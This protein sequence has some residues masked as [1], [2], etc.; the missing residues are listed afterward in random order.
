MGKRHARSRES[1]FDEVS[2]S[3][4]GVLPAER[5]P[6]AGGR[7]HFI[8]STQAREG[9]SGGHL[10]DWIGFRRMALVGDRYPASGRTGLSI[11]RFQRILRRENCSVEGVSRSDD[12]DTAMIKYV[13]LEDGGHCSAILTDPIDGDEYTRCCLDASIGV[14]LGPERLNHLNMW[15][16]F[17]KFYTPG[18]GTLLIEYSFIVLDAP[19]ALIAMTLDMFHG[20]VRFIMQNG[21][22][23]PSA[24][25][26]APQGDVEGSYTAAGSATAHADISPSDLSGIERK[27]DRIASTLDGYPGNDLRAVV[28]R[29]EDI[30]SLLRD[31]SGKL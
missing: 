2:E 16:K 8:V 4:G 3:F 28:N 5:A 24:T 26:H 30:R 25:A 15:S 21:F 17:P 31:I 11:D 22:R 14:D 9:K 20:S 7:K 27:L 10:L 12:G 1:K 23:Y 19:D 6:L 13:Y 29:L 18:D